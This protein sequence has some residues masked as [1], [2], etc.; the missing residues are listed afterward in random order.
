M[1]EVRK[2][3]QLPDIIIKSKHKDD[4]FVELNSADNAL[5]HSSR[6]F[7][8]PTTSKS[9][10]VNENHTTTCKIYVM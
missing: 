6:T 1:G 10:D 8:V 3:N 9:H 4:I 2:N 5:I 7:Q